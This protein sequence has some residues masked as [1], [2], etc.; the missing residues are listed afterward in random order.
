ME[1]KKHF[2]VLLISC[3]KDTKLLESLLNDKYRIIN[4]SNVGLRTFYILSDIPET[5]LFETVEPEILDIRIVGIK[6]NP[7]YVDTIKSLRDDG[8]KIDR[9]STMTVTMLKYKE[10]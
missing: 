3:S 7:N 10:K 8:F 1:S 2:R 4:Q 5:S 6:G 9:A